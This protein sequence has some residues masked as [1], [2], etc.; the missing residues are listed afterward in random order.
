MK[1][2]FLCLFIIVSY[3]NAQPIEENYVNYYAVDNSLDGQIMI[4]KMN[5]LRFFPVYAIHDDI[6]NVEV[7]IYYGNKIYT[8]KAEKRGEGKYWQ[9]LLPEFELGDAIQRM[10]VEV[11]F[12]LP[13]KHYAKFRNEAQAIK[14]SLL[15]KDTKKIESIQNELLSN[16]NIIIEQSSKLSQRLI[17]FQNSINELNKNDLTNISDE[18]LKLN[19]MLMPV[20][21]NLIFV[22][23]LFS[24]QGLN[25][26]DSVYKAL[27][28][29]FDELNNFLDRVKSK[30]V[31]PLLKSI[32]D[33]SENYKKYFP[34]L[35]EI[36]NSLFA[37]LKLIS[38]NVDN[39][40]SYIQKFD[41]LVILEVKAK[42]ELRK[43]IL[44][45]LNLDLADS[46]YSGQSV[47][48]SDVIIE[49]DFRFAKILYRNY[50]SALRK[51]PA[52]DPAEKMGIF[53]V[54]YVP[55]PVTSTTIN[56]RGNLYLV[57][58]T[59]EG[60]ITVFEIG[61]SFGD[62]I[63][64]GDQFVFP[65]FSFK[66]LGVALALSQKLFAHDAEIKA[67][68]LTYDFNSYGSIGL[69]ANLARELIRPYFSFGINKKAFEALLKGLVGVFK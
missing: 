8:R 15:N 16:K 20:E 53:R 6:T 42:E 33:A 67:I 9:C 26:G 55:F 24:I 39:I 54:R 40:K 7:T 11:K 48:R 19:K 51:M 62:A 50:N 63:V 31:D 27:K 32:I 2:I 45:E 60:A 43:S 37:T 18:I 57:P 64:P 41:E 38:E 34:E 66:R 3:S 44:K 52:L 46:M 47:R 12:D 13:S 28:M 21:Q 17:S 69:G 68:A 49:P 1:K 5:L 10:E 14:D 25:Q 61:L 36:A 65:E 59:G 4:E 30:N 29:P 22:T 23:A 56:K 35:K 58:F